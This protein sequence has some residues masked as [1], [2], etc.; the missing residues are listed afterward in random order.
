MKYNEQRHDLSLAARSTRPCL[1]PTVSAP[2]AQPYG[3]RFTGQLEERQSPRCMLLV[4][5]G[6]RETLYPLSSSF[7][8]GPV[9]V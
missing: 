2:M 5:F 3:R 8:M 4:I 1:D 9:R 7:L 6:E